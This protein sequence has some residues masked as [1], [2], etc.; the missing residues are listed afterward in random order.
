MGFEPPLIQSY[1]RQSSVNILVKTRKKT[2]I[3]WTTSSEDFQKLLDE[4]SSAVEVLKKLGFNG[5]NGNHRT[6]KQRMFSGE[7]DLTLFEENKKADESSRSSRLRFLNRLG[8][9]D[10]F[11]EKSNYNR[12]QLKKRMVEECGVEYKCVE[13]GVSDSYNNKPISLQLDHINGVSDDNRLENL[14]FLC[15]N[16]HSQTE[17]FCGKH[18]VQK[19]F[20]KCGKQIH[21]KSNMCRSCGSKHGFSKL[22]EFKTKIN[23]PATELLKEW[24]WREPT[25]KIAKQLGLSDKAVEKH[26]L[27][28][29]LTKPPRG[30]WMKNKP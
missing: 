1:N 13:C 17:T 7:F 10:V 6:V 12:S 21:R 28:L 20:C 25:V 3:V 19:N 30:Y 26:I 29:G 4:S 16:C 24:L 18:K 27:K 15:P 14:R 22:R 5:Y 8:T 9:H 11:K 23:W 2:S